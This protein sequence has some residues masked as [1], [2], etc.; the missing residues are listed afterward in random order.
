MPEERPQDPPGR[1]SLQLVPG[2]SCWKKAQGAYVAGKGVKLG[3]GGSYF[4]VSVSHHSG[5]SEEPAAAQ[6]GGGGMAWGGG[7]RVRGETQL[8]PEQE[9]GQRGEIR[10]SLGACSVTWCVLSVLEAE[11]REQTFV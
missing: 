10:A 3:V 7:P 2:L 8:A 4:N 11:Q 6:P 9:A 1:F 5:R